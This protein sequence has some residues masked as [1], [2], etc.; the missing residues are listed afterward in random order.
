MAD[1]NSPRLN[2][3]NALLDRASAATLTARAYTNPQV[4][5]YAGPQSARNIPT[6]GVPGLLQHYSVYQTIEVPR[7]RETRR[8]VA[9]LGRVGQSYQ[10]DSERLSV[11][12]TVKHYFYE[13]LRWKHEI[14]HARANLALVQDLRNRV[15]IEVRVGEKGRLELTRAEAELARAN[16]AVRSAQINFVNAIALLRAAIA[17]PPDI[18]YDPRGDLE[19]PMRFGPLNELRSLVLRN[20]P[21]I[22]EANTAIEQADAELE[23]QRAL[24]IPQPIFYGEWEKQP[25]LTFW[26]MGFTVPLPVW[27]RRRGQIADSQAAIRQ[28]SAIRNQRQL[29]LTAALERAY[30]S[31]QL[32]DQ[33]ATSLQ[34]GS[35]REAESAVDAAMAAY[36]FGERGIVEVLDAQRVLQSV[37][38]DL[39]DARFARQAALVDLEELGVVP[40]GEK[41]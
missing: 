28:S 39:L 32:A 41:H 24:R 34:A 7:E 29:E 31:Y 8:R 10:R 33:Q 16:F 4:E 35:L 36:R 17:A 1:Q 9:D 26:R 27:D 25:D 40:S 2:A 6:P 3:A 5:F 22:G 21:V 37:R 19:P 11:T 38:G 20:H 14:E 12:A 18:P 13:A 23:R 30:E 15:E